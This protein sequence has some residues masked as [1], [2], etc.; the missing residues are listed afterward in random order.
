M[1]GEKVIF[2]QRESLYEKGDPRTSK[3]NANVRVDWANVE[4]RI[5]P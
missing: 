1:R 3:Q 2:S 5:Y 4:H